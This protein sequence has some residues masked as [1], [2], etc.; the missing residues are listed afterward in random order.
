MW[1]LNT[2]CICIRSENQKAKLISPWESSKYPNL[3]GIWQKGN[4]TTSKL[5][6]NPSIYWP[7]VHI[8]ERSY[9]PL[10]QSFFLPCLAFHVLG[11]L[12]LHQNCRRPTKKQKKISKCIMVLRHQSAL[13][14]EHA[15]WLGVHSPK[16]WQ[17][18]RPLRWF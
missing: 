8:H 14:E 4:F 12:L 7:L 11:L 3:K 18:A 2:R 6:S 9:R 16:S 5:P 10:L 15:N 1:F 17:H 13:K